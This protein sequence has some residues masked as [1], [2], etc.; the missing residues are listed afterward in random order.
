[1]PRFLE[2]KDNIKSRKQTKTKTAFKYWLPS[3]EYLDKNIFGKHDDIHTLKSIVG[4]VLLF[5][6]YV[7]V[8]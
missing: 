8:Q 4:M 5:L 1:M 2:R 6:H 7:T 3:D